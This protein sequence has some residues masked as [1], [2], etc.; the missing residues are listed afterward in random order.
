MGSEN[1]FVA[2][3]KKKINSLSRD[4]K[5]DRK[6]VGMGKERVERRQA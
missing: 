5:D 3:Q 2:V 1:F 4:T 6:E